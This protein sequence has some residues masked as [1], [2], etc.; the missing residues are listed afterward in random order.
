MGKALAQLWMGLQTAFG[1]FDILMQAVL[2]LC[3]WAERTSKSFAE[4]A[5][6]DRI[7][8]QAERRLAMGITPEATEVVA[9][10]KKAKATTQEE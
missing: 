6:E 7:A 1:A 5:E 3:T 2:H 9:K 4:E 10:A 8:K